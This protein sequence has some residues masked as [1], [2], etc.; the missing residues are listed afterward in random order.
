[1]KANGKMTKNMVK[2][3]SFILT[4][5]RCT[6]ACGVT[7]FQNVGQWRIL[8]DTRHLGQLHTLYKRLATTLTIIGIN[9]VWLVRFRFKL[10][11]KV[12]TQIAGFC[13]S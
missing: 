3:S 10:V 6:R 1:M 2:E 8:G 12:I 4:V 7:T 9:V 11:A 5:G 13:L